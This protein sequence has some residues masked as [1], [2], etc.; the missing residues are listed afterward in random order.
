MQKIRKISKKF[1]LETICILDGHV[2]VMTNW[3]KPYASV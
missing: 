1:L 2:I 3:P